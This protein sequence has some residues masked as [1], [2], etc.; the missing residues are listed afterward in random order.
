M[1]EVHFS[2][3]KKADIEKFE[4]I[5]ARYKKVSEE[6]G[7]EIKRV[8]YITRSEP[9]PSLYENADFSVDTIKAS[10]KDGELKTNQILKGIKMS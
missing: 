7:A 2:S 1:L 4:K 5:R 9:F 10:I 6:H 3:E 8:H